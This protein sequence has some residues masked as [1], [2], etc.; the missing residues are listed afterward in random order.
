[1]ADLH[2]ILF[3]MHV[4][5]SLALGIWATVILARGEPISGHFWGAIVTYALLA[6]GTLALGLLLL[7]SGYEPRSGRVLVY[8]LYMIWL[9]IIMPGLFSLMNGRDDRQAALAYALLAFFN[10]S[11]SFSMV[12]RELVGP[13]L[14][15]T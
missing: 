7:L 11:T 6:A 9:A 14:A 10:A 5:Y 1:M 4:L 8:V 3:N 12:Q 15:Q 13:W 2:Q